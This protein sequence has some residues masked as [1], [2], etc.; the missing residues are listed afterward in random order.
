M[1]H[2]LIVKHSFYGCKNICVLVLGELFLDSV[3]HNVE[4][5]QKVLFLEKESSGRKSLNLCYNNLVLVSVYYGASFL[6][7]LFISKTRSWSRFQLVCLV[8]EVIAIFEIFQKIQVFFSRY[9]AHLI[10]Q[11][12]FLPSAMHC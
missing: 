9:K 11:S 6:L 3:F 10:T 2:P 1:K 8:T 12:S 4:P 5:L 7:S